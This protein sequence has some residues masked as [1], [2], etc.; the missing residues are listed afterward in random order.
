MWPD[1]EI[2]VDGVDFMAMK[3]ADITGAFDASEAA[4]KTA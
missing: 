4:N 3:E 2:E 1:A